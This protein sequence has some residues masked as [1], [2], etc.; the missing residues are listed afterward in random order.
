MKTTPTRSAKALPSTMG[1]AIKAGQNSTNNAPEADIPKAAVQLSRLNVETIARKPS[2]D[3]DLQSDLASSD[4][5]TSLK[6]SPFN[7]DKKPA[8][9]STIRAT[10]NSQANRQSEPIPKKIRLDESSEFI[11]CN[12]H[13]EN[14]NTLEKAIKSGN[15]KNLQYFINSGGSELLNEPIAHLKSAPK[16]ALSLC[17]DHSNKEMFKYLTENN[18]HI[19]TQDNEGDLHYPLTKAASLGHTDLVATLKKT[20][21]IQAH[22]TDKYNRTALMHAAMGGHFETVKEMLR[23]HPKSRVLHQSTEKLNAIDYALNSG[24]NHIAEYLI[25]HIPNYAPTHESITIYKTSK[26]MYEENPHQHSKYITPQPAPALEPTS[27]SQ[28]VDASATSLQAMPE[29]AEDIDDLRKWIQNDFYMYSSSHASDAGIELMKLI[30]SG[31]D[32]NME[33]KSGMT[34]LRIA[35]CN[36][37]NHPLSVLIKAGANVD[38]ADKDNR[39][40]LFFAVLNDRPVNAHH[41]IKAGANVNHTDNDLNT[42]LHYVAMGD[43]SDCVKLLINSGANLDIRNKEGHTALDVANL[44]NNTEISKILTEAANRQGHRMKQM[45]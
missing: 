19:N 42:P 35:A 5:N 26:K 29:V 43:E 24:H 8:W 41:L 14:Y 1:D 30:E 21:S 18:F 23:T 31:E 11:A 27:R 6:R 2:Q 44:N 34:P 22:N 36:S 25:R 15:L 16:S 13:E 45:A 12:N 28:D 40:A 38:L 4:E 9:T 33:V 3:S 10:K 17:I 32:F 20:N 37:N 39:T 7:N